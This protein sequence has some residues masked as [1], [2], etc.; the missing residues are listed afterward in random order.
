MADLNNT[1]SQYNLEEEEEEAAIVAAREGLNY[2]NLTNVPISHEMVNLFDKE[3]MLKYRFVPYLKFGDK[4]TVASAAPQ[5][6]ELQALLAKVADTKNLEI[7]L[8]QISN[9]SFLSAYKNYE[10]I[11]NE[12]IGQAK[13]TP[14]FYQGVANIEAV[15]ELVRKTSTTEL[16][17]LLVFSAS[18]LLSSDI[19]LEPSETEFLVRFR[20]DGILQNV[21]TLPIHVYKQLLSRIMFMAKMKMDVIDAPQDGAITIKFP[22]GH[23]VDIRVSVMPSTFGEAIVMRLLGEESSV[24]ALDDFGFRPDALAAIKEAISHPHGMILTSGPTGSGKSSTMYSILLYLR[25]PGVKIIT[26]ENPVEIKMSNIEQSQVTPGEGY[27]FADGLRASLRQD[28][29]ILM[30]GEIRDPQTAEIAIQAAMT[31]HLLLSTVHTNSAPA[32]F[33]R[34]LEIGVRPYLLAGSI[35]LIM[36][37]RLIRK[38]CPDCKEE[39]TATPE[40]QQLLRQKLEPIKSKLSPEIAQK[41]DSEALILSH[42]KGCAKC[43]NTGYKGRQIVVEYLVPDAQ[44][45]SLII[46][47]TSINDFEKVAI[48]QGMITMEQDGLIKA[49]EGESTIEEVMRVTKN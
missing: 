43:N 46:K 6:P 20:I 8:S 1:I 29:D 34:L 40:E 44:I 7:S 19:H 27:E 38:I 12:I 5:N 30:V 45:E 23:S 10:A 41:L 37:Q 4:V 42:G 24:L 18:Q 49:L 9:S 25:K 31:G 35:N 47:N 48:D 33:V 15:V 26:L 14:A 17:D 21:V 32:V 39:Y 3:E 2:I 11:Y 28:P 36:A 13:A 16:L 22:T